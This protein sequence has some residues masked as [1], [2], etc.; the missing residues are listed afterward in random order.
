MINNK[1][2]IRAIISYIPLIKNIL[3]KSGTSPLRGSYYYDIYKLHKERLVQSAFK[4]PGNF[5]GE[6]GPGDTLGVGICAILD[7]FKQYFALDIIHHSNS[8][9]NIEALNEIIKLFPTSIEQSKLLKNEL[10]RLEDNNSIFKYYVPWN[11]ESIIAENSLD[12]IISNAVLEHVPSIDNIYKIM[13]KW[14][15]PGGYMS[16]IIDY[17]AHE[18][19]DNWQEHLYLNETYWKFLLHGRLY[20]I[21][22][23]PHSM[24]VK[25]ICEAGFELVLDLRIKDRRIDRKK[26]DNSI[27]ALFNDDDLNTRS[28]H[29]IAK[30]K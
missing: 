28:G 9:K 8:V 18:F 16:H 14:I 26:I 7:G 24:H 25:R 27:K 23:L 10:E 12:L 2:K 15:K 29:I 17:G 5:I 13:F 30:K 22:R 11:D 4:F 19:S 6:I 20:P 1:K 21:N 3:R